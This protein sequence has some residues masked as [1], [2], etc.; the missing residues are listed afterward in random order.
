MNFNDLRTACGDGTGQVTL[1]LPRQPSASANGIRLTTQGGPVG[2]V[3]C[4]NH[5][6]NTVARFDCKAILR[7][8]ARME[9]KAGRS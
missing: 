7:W 9:K 5:Q 2:Y 4:V 6:G 3:V 1:V 8:I